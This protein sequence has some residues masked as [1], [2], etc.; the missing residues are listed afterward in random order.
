MASF[1]NILETSE[2]GIRNTMKTIDKIIFGTNFPRI[3]ATLFHIHVITDA[4][5]FRNS[6]VKP[7]IIAASNSGFHAFIKYITNN[8][9]AITRD[10]SRF[11]F[12]SIIIN[13]EDGINK[14]RNGTATAKNNQYSDKKQNN[15]YGKQPPFFPFF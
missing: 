2:M 1:L 14:R 3:S 5:L 15:Y 13:L 12:L 6:P 9:V 8:P 4:G 11:F 10:V 7:I